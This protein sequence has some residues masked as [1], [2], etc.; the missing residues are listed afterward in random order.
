MEITFS[1]IFSAFSLLIG[2]G[3]IG[4]LLTLKYTRRKEAAEAESAGAQATKEVQEVY[5]TMLDD[6]KKEREEQKVYVDQLKDDRRQLRDERNEL[7][8]RQDELEESVRA[9]RIEVARNG[10]MVEAIR[11]FLCGRPN[12]KDRMLVT[13]S[14]EGEVKERKSR[15]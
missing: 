4:Y 7:R 9:L 1:D 14:A 15:K 12:C 6:M 11:P 3:G 8:K 2:G 13:V 5:Q 10:R